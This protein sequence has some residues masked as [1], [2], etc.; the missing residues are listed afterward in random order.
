MHPLT[1]QQIA[2]WTGAAV[3][4]AAAAVCH[5]VSTD[6][7]TVRAGD[8]FIALSGENFDAHDFV[9]QAAEAGATAAIVSHDISTSVP[10][11]FPLLIVSDTLQALQKLAAAYRRSL[12]IKIVCITG[13][14]GK[15]STKDMVAAVLGAH[16]SV[17]KTQGNLNNHIGLP[18]SLLKADAAHEFG[19]FE[20]GMNHAGEIAPLAE[21]AKPDI[22]IVTNVGT[23]HIEFL[24]TREAIA[25]EK[26]AL[27]R[28]LTSSG[29]AILPATDDFLSILKRDLAAKTITAGV[30]SGDVCASDLQPVSGGTQFR[31]SAGGSS[32][33][34]F[35]P[36]AG[37]H[38]VS[39]AAL[40]IAT[41]LTCGIPLDTCAAALSKLQLTSG[42]M[43]IR[44]WNGITFLD[45]SYNAN[46]DSMAAALRTLQS[47]GASTRSIAVLGHMGEL[48]HFSEAGHASVGTLAAELNVHTLITVGEQANGI[49]QAA[50]NAGHS[51]VHSVA[52]HAAAASLLSGMLEHGDT[53]LFKG[54]RA[55]GMERIPRLLES[56][57]QPAAHC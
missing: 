42:R 39:N 47:L 57:P 25:E 27:P 36:V 7:R 40:A 16:F 44:T 10:D 45:D 26:A 29:N 35:I 48:G 53:V 24:G 18:L 52:D 17:V 2:D 13:S 43:E 38:M 56:S 28:S 54:S 23:A 19:V 9:A 30:N 33:D 32:A 3:P 55:A 6:T 15:T 41:G 49:A 46:P 31:I 4:D 20:I 37:L 51:R 22:A 34:V 8:L 14:N 50:E 5:G 21:I 11:G 1:L 12:G